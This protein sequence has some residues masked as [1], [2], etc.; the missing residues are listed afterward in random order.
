VP[1]KVITQVLSRVFVQRYTANTH[2]A[3][4]V[5][6]S[7]LNTVASFSRDHYVSSASLFVENDRIMHSWKGVSL[8]VVSGGQIHVKVKI[9]YVVLNLLF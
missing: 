8:V 5:V 1:H 6:I 2:A 4:L 3:K 9:D 7:S